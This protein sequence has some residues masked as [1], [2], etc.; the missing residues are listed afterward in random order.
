MVLE[1]TDEPRA[2]EELSVSSKNTSMV[3][4]PNWVVAERSKKE[5]CFPNEGSF[6]CPQGKSYIYYP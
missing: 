4:D 3:Q 5:Y 6:F 2:L 1:A